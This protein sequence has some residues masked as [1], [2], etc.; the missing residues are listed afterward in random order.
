MAEFFHIHGYNGSICPWLNS[1][2]HRVRDI[3][4]KRLGLTSDEWSF[5]DIR[6]ANGSGTSSLLQHHHVDV[7]KFCNSSWKFPEGGIRFTYIEQLGYIIGKSS[8]SIQ[9][10]QQKVTTKFCSV[11]FN[12]PF[13]RYEQTL[14]IWCV[15]C[16]L[17]KFDVHSS[18]IIFFPSTIWTGASWMVLPSGNSMKKIPSCLDVIISEE[19]VIRSNR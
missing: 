15:T 11:H 9:L 14:K 12:V 17:T 16:F 10:S 18:M 7:R 1:H 5:S 6:W 19:M 3:F 8:T 2:S 13:G 4:L